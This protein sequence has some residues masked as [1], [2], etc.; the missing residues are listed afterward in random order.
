MRVLHCEGPC[1]DALIPIPSSEVRKQ[2][3]ES[4]GPKV[5]GQAGGRVGRKARTPVFNFLP[6]S[7]NQRG[8]WFPVFT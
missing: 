6:S 2:G 4:N 1:K 7:C 8:D 3:L 5:A